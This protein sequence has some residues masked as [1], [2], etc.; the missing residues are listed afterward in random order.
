MVPGNT[1]QAAAFCASGLGGIAMKIF[2]GGNEMKKLFLILS[3]MMIFAMTVM[4][5]SNNLKLS[6]KQIRVTS[7]NGEIVVFQLYETN[8]ARQLYDQLPLNNL[9]LS[10]CHTGDW[11]FSPFKR[12]EVTRTEAY[13]NGKK[14]ELQ[15]YAPWGVVVMLYKDFDSRDDVH[16]LGIAVAGINNIEK[17]I[18]TVRVEKVE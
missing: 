6:T 9:S 8:A 11:D 17:M 13:R 16:R 3:I 7:S 15:Y 12:L 5:Q 14:G 10:N 2:F 4:A 18:G 1:E